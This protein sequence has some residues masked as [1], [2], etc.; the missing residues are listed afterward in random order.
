MR[1]VCC[2]CH[3]GGGAGRGGRRC[4]GEE[5]DEGSGGDGIEVER[6]VVCSRGFEFSRRG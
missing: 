3:R 4:G 1:I 2:A 6:G 5:V